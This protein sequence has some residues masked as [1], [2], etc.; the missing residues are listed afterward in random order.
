MSMLKNI[1]ITILLGLFLSHAPQFGI[2][3]AQPEKKTQSKKDDIKEIQSWLKQLGLYPG[4]IDG[5]IGKNSR[6]AW[7]EF[8]KAAGIDSNSDN[9]VNLLRYTAESTKGR[10]LSL[11]VASWWGRK[12]MEAAENSTNAYSFYEKGRCNRSLKFYE[13]AYSQRNQSLGEDHE[14]TK[15]SKNNLRILKNMIKNGN[16]DCKDIPRKKNTSDQAFSMLPDTV[17]SGDELSTTKGVDI[18]LCQ[19]IC[20]DQV[21]CSAFTYNSSARICTTKSKAGEKITFEGAISGVKNQPE[22]LVDDKPEKKKGYVFRVWPHGKLNLRSGASMDKSV[23]RSLNPGTMLEEL[24]RD[25]EWSEVQAKRGSRGWVN[26]GYILDTTLVKLSK[27]TA[28]KKRN[29]RKTRPKSRPRRSNPPQKSGGKCSVEL[30][31]YLR[32]CTTKYGGDRYVDGGTWER[33]RGMRSRLE[34]KQKKGQC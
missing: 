5:V 26:N 21:S 18:E 14:L 9:S 3:L 13:L 22:T 25:E 11:S 17:V 23:I 7:M 19:S 29:K 8:A 15:E 10:N 30:E 31:K 2:A 4:A 12:A 28:A 24:R 32:L 33:C 27:P 1:L 16:A 6:K 34:W 20:A